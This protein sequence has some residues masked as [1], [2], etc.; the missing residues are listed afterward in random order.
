MGFV[1]RPAADAGAGAPGG[2]TLGVVVG[3]TD[4]LA[5]GD[6]KV[7]ALPEVELVSP[8]EGSGATMTGGLSG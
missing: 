8:D 5:L 3:A 6:G 2:E 4:P 1:E 7:L